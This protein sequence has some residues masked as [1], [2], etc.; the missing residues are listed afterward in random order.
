MHLRAHLCLQYPVTRQP[1][2]TGYYSTGERLRS[3]RSGQAASCG[4]ISS[5]LF[6]PLVKCS[7]QPQLLRFRCQV[8]LPCQA[9][10]TD[11]LSSLNR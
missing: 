2:V 3:M 9:W 11:L 10:V 4:N 5:N 6:A 8:Q 1:E 7:M